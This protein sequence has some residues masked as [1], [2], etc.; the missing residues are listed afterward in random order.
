M[1]VVSVLPSRAEG[2]FGALRERAVSLIHP[3][4][5][6]GDHGVAESTFD[7]ALRLIARGDVDVD[8]LV[9]H[10]MSGIDALPA[11][12]AVTADKQAHGAINPVQ[13]DLRSG[14][15]A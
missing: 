15:A 6:T 13:V 14:R 12:I 10:R 1:V 8:A 2:P 5:G 3:G 9:T 4:S 7:Y 11:A